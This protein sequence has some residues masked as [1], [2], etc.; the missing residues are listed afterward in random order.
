MFIPYLMKQISILV[1][2]ILLCVSYNQYEHVIQKIEN[3]IKTTTFY[4]IR[5]AEK[6][7][8]DPTNKNPHLTKTGQLRANNWSAILHH[9]PFHVIYSTDY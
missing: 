8:S 6:D 7:R 1:I 9:I 4:F 2:C 3:L 5:H